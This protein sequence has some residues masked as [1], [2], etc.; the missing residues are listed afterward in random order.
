MLKCTKC[1]YIREQTIFDTDLEICYCPLCNNKLTIIREL[2]P[3]GEYCEGEEIIESILPSYFKEAIRRD[4]DILGND[5][6]WLAIES[7]SPCRV[8][9]QYRKYFFEVG[10]KIREFTFLRIENDILYLCNI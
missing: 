4:I 2:K 1:D 3:K 9:I 7:I 6:A 5:R 8:R 10:G